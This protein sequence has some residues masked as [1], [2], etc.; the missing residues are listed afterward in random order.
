[1]YIV[2]AGAGEV[3]FHIAKSLRSGKH[4]IAIIEKEQEPLERAETLDALVI[5]GNSANPSTALLSLEERSL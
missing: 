4:N 3:G 5:H 2:I 1:M